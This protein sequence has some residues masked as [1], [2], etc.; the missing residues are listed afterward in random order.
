MIEYPSQLGLQEQVLL[1]PGMN[2]FCINITAVDDSEQESSS[3]LLTLVL[4]HDSEITSSVRVIQ[5]NSE[6]Q[7]AILDDDSK[8]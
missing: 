3:E 7:L 8:L 5:G 6:V 2:N 1:G 4:S